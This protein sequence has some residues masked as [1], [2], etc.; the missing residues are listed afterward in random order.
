MKF[1]IPS[2]K[3][4]TTITKYTLNLLSCIPED[5]IFVFVYKD[6]LSDYKK[7]CKANIIPVD[8]KG[9]AFTRNYMQNFAKDYNINYF[10]MVDD[11]IINLRKRTTQNEKGTWK[12]KNVSPEDSIIELQKMENICLENGKVVSGMC[13]SHIG[14]T[15]PDSLFA[16]M[17]YFSFCVYL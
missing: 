15:F 1:F 6:E 16:N 5:D 3:R 10:F 8:K 11:D 7:V 12:L 14:W 17:L 13:P 2:Y 9:I 4:S